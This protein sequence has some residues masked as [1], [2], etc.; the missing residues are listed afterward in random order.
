[1]GTFWGTRKERLG[2]VRKLL[3]DARETSYVFKFRAGGFVQ[4]AFWKVRS[5]PFGSRLCQDD[6]SERK[7]PGS[8][9]FESSPSSWVQ[10]WFQLG[11]VLGSFFGVKRC[12][13]NE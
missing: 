5:E 10:H 4:T 11:P 12:R 6:S 8:A 2:M 13:I 7:S 3:T 1:M 9:E